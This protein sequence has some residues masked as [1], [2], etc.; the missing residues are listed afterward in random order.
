MRTSILALFLWIAV[1]TP[2][3]ACPNCK[4]AVANNA[5]DS[6]RLADGY[7]WSIMVMMATP[8]A[9]LGTGTCYLVR[10][11]RRGLLPQF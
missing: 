7:S 11:S 8:F 3:L 10:A 5:D 6:S 1:S 4:E 2:A 9:L